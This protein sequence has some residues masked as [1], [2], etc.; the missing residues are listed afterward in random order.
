MNIFTMS[1]FF[2]ISLFLIN[3]MRAYL[4]SYS[5]FASALV[6]SYT[7]RTELYPPSDDISKH[8]QAPHLNSAK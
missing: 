8:L 7:I 2:L 1:F 4:P 6:H 3:I 5:P